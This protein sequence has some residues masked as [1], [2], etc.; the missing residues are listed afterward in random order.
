MATVQEDVPIV[1]EG[2]GDVMAEA[3]QTNGKEIVVL[4]QVVEAEEE[5]KDGSAKTAKADQL[6]ESLAKVPI[7]GK[8]ARRI[9]LSQLSLSL[10]LKFILSYILI[11]LSQFL[12]KDLC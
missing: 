11:S 5:K 3:N 8:K 4:D 2:N 6:E 9:K 12:S 7:K 10:L 1:T